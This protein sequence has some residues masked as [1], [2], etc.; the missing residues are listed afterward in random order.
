MAIS[1]ISGVSLSA[2]S[3]YSGVSL[4]SLGTLSGVSRTGNQGGI[5]TTNL[6]QHLDAG[7]SNSYAGSGTTWTDLVSNVD[8][9]FVNTPTYSSTE[10][11]GSFFFDGVD[12]AIRFDYDDAAPIRIGEDSGEVN[13]IGGSGITRTYGDL[14]DDGG[15]T[16][17]AWIRPITDPSNV[18]YPFAI[19]NNNCSVPTSYGTG[20]QYYQGIDFIVL[21]NGNIRCLVF[22]GNG[23]NAPGDRRDFT[24][25]GGGVGS[26]A[27]SWVNVAFVL[28]GDNVNGAT[29]VDIETDGKLYVQG[30]SQTT[31]HLTTG[32]GSGLGYRSKWISSNTMKLHG[33]IGLHRGNYRTGYIS[34]VLIYNDILTDSEV[35][36]NYNATK[37]R[38]GY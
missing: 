6:V 38:Y 14:D 33:G 26:Y 5:V 27:D 23:G 31:T 2:M 9:T 13:A 20:Y 29:G 21:G 15:I 34:E 8:G 37:A 11:G 16:V 25:S 35:E 32:A 30:T 36:Q 4:A 24:T 7:D 22:D 3:K 28:P 1:K 12:E 17:Q 10:G 18:T 19:W